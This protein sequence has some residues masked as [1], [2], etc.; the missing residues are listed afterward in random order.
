MGVTKNDIVRLQLYS[1]TNPRKYVVNGTEY[2]TNTAA[3]YFTKDFTLF[4]MNNNGNIS[5]NN[6]SR[7]YY[8]NSDILKLLSCYVI[9]EYI[10]N[11]GTLCSS[12]VA[13]M[14]DTL[15]GVFYTNDGTGT[16]SH[17]GDINL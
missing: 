6:N 4:A 2:T 9:D 16:F 5:Y 3:T 12:G 7:L 1:N 15:T 14:V 17:G 8:F 11:K 10:N 13:G